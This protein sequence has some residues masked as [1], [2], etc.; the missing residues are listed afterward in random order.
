[1]D[2][3]AIYEYACIDLDSEP[4]TCFLAQFTDTEC[5]GRLEKA[6]LIEKQRLRK[7]G[8]SEHMWAPEVWRPAC[9]RHHFMLDA[10]RGLVVPRSLL[11]VE[12]ELFADRHGLGWYL[13]RKYG[14]REEAAA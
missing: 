12:T 14:E 13:D 11:P 2:T 4:A 7:E 6:H 5:A 8:L 9:K 1:M 3:E 10:Y